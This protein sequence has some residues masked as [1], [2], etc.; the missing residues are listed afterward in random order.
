MRKAFTTL[1]LLALSQAGI[2]AQEWK[3]DAVHSRVMFTVM[4]MLVSE[5]AGRFTDFS[6]TLQQGKEDFSG[7]A[8]EATIKTASITTDNEMRD[9]HLRSNDF[10][11]A[12]KFPAITFKST[13]FEK[14]GDKTYRIKGDLTMR[15]VTKEV[16]LDGKMLGMVT[17]PQGNTRVG[18]RATTIVDRFDY[19]VKWDRA[20][21][22]GGLIAGKDVSI[23]LSAEFIKQKGKN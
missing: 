16:V 5:V 20:L 21:D 7:S 10:F 18:F 23:T 13:A 6:V 15:D 11:N 17:D 3:I 22:S 8:V 4:H 12:E 14:T 2:Q 1:A 9:K 19:G